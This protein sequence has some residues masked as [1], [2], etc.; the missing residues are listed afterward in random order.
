VKNR[1]IGD[2]GDFAK[3]GLLRAIAGPGRDRA[4][5]LGVVWYLTP[6]DGRQDGRHI[7]YL[8]ASRPNPYSRA[9]PRVYGRLRRVVH[10]LGREVHHVQS[11]GVLPA[12]TAFYPEPLAFPQLSPRL[13]AGRLGHRDAWLEGAVRATAGCDLV[14]L[15]PDNGLAP[16]AVGRHTDA[17]LRYAYP[18]EL[19]RFVDLGK[20]VIL[21]SSSAGPRPMLTSSGGV[22]AKSAT[23]CRPGRRR[24]WPSGGGTGCRW[25]S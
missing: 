10:Q 14:F 24:L 6:D 20:S 13:V 12:R 21:I 5:R 7:H 16:P 22:W 25:R 2:L 15:D 3:Y 18:D 1:Y 4:F 23:R 8:S 11:A 19:R 9:D 17:G